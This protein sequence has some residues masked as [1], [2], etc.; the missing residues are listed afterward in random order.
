ME[1]VSA[2]T[3]IFRQDEPGEDMFVISGGRVRLTLEGGGRAEEIA[4]L[5]AGDFFGELSLLGGNRRT[6][7]A[8]AVD[9][10]ILLRIRRDVFAMIRAMKDKF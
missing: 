6:A 5:Q 3:T 2:G 4:V 7:T 10:C 1:Q 8:V 9:D